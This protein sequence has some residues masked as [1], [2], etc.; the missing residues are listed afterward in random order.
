M[1][2][3]KPLGINARLVGKRQEPPK[4]ADIAREQSCFL[5]MIGFDK[6]PLRHCWA[7]RGDVIDDEGKARLERAH[8]VAHYL[9]GPNVPSNFFLLCA[10]CH[11]EQPDFAEPI[12][13]CFWLVSRE[14]DTE[15]RCR[16]A[17]EIARAGERYDLATRRV[18]EL[19]RIQ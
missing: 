19:M 18:V 15:R 10:R 5:E 13:A 7:C 8:I 6:D 14:L 11:F 9:G 2:A 1:T 4:A 3:P 12:K 17:M 16:M